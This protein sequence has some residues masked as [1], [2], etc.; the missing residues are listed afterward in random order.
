MLK[1]L[2]HISNEQLTQELSY[3]EA[4]FTE[5]YNRYWDKLFFIA[6]IKLKDV[7]MAEE[8]VQ[9][10]FLDLWKRRKQ[11]SITV[12]I[13]AYL[14]V[15]VKYRI[16]NAH[17]KIK[18]MQAHLQTQEKT[19]FYPEQWLDEKELQKNFELLVSQL[20][21]KCRITYKLSREEGLSLKEIANRM[22]VSQKAVEANLTRSLKLL[23]FGLRKILL[24]L[25]TTLNF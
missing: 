15:A 25:L 22:K 16:I 9:D 11:V 1:P 18:R 10:V 2:T 4:A 13:E 12:S 6:A 8:I 14:S 24:L 7:A 19:I 21:E 5:I 20:P 17:A 3:S 23:R